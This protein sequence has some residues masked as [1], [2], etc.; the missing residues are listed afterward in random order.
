MDSSS[1][2]GL[3]RRP[4]PISLS[5]LYL[6]QIDPSPLLEFLDGDCLVQLLLQKRYPFLPRFNLFCSTSH[7]SVSSSGNQAAVLKVHDYH[8]CKPRC[9]LTSS[10]HELL[11]EYPFLYYNTVSGGRWRPGSVM[12]RTG[13]PWTDE[14]IV[15]ILETFRSGAG[16]V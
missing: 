1:A 5:G 16:H 2:L 7:L 4:A 10:S 14:P 8:K 11:F 13:R 3:T 6:F 12:M 15:D 9:F